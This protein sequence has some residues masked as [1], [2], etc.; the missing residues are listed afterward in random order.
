MV[1]ARRGC[2]Q[3][4]APVRSVK[5]WHTDVTDATFQTEVV[6]R[7]K[8]VPVVVDLWAPWCGPCRTLGPIIEKVVDETDGKVVAGEGQRRRE[9]GHLARR[10]G[11]RASPRS[12]RCA[13]GRS[14]T[15]SS[16]PTPSPRSSGSS[17]ACC[18]PRRRPTVSSTRRGGRRGEPPQGARPRPRQRGRHRRPGRAAH[19]RRWERRTATAG[20]RHSRCSTRIPENER[21]R[22]VAADSTRFGD[23]RGGRVRR[24]PQRAA[25]PGEGRRRARGRSSSTSSR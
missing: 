24:D 8:S 1:S 11:S 12:T 9:P 7:S 23:H 20:A 15:A 18:R 13:T 19:R 6:E 3:T 21:T 10:S 4:L 2:G 16:G 25:R 17:T 22:K 5:S 14:S